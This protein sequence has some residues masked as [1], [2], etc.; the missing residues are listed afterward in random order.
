MNLCEA[1]ERARLAPRFGGGSRRRL[2]CEVAEQ[3]VRVRQP[4]GQDLA[5][6]SQQLGDAG[7]VDAVVDASARPTAVE[8][9]LLAQHGEV[10]GGAAGIQVELGLKVAHG[11]LALAE[12]L[13]DPD[14]HRVAENPE[15][16]GLYDVDRVGAHMR[17]ARGVGRG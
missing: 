17:C 2:V 11:A 1:N 5:G 9:A 3:R 12:E 15:E 4:G 13:E 10:L 8:Q 16:L 14:S 7:V 6:Y